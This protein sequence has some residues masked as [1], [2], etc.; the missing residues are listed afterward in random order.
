MAGPF[1]T[2]RRWTV[3]ICQ[4]QL[5]KRPYVAMTAPSRKTSESRSRR[6]PVLADDEGD[7][8]VPR[9]ASLPC[10][11]SQFPNR[12][13]GR[14]YAIEPGR[15]V[16]VVPARHRG[17]HGRV[18]KGAGLGDRQQAG[19]RALRGCAGEDGLHGP[20]GADW[21]EVRGDGKLRGIDVNL[22]DMPDMAQTLAAVAMF[23]E[24]KTTVRGVCELRIKETDRIAALENELGKLGEGHRAGG[25]ACPSS[26]RRTSARPQIDTY[27]DHRMA[28]SFAVIG[29]KAAGIVIR[30]PGCVSKT[31]PD[32]FE[33]FDAMR[34]TSLRE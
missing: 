14:T 27:D 32:F 7:N 6:G 22:A 1:A 21:L 18:R 19:R 12:Y 26:R 28:M 9:Q 17:G 13:R 29:A 34:H 20:A 2:A 25:T 15:L 23:A 16:R 24:G 8:G 5:T 11:W 10:L 31:F 33:R 4:G 30:D 3:G